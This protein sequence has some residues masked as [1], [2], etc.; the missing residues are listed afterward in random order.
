MA[1]ANEPPYSDIKADGYVSGAAPDVARAVLKKLGVPSGE[2]A[3]LAR[4]AVRQARAAGIDDRDA[5]GL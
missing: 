4:E 2:P 5:R 3:R 1:V